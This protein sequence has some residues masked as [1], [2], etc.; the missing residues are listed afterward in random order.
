[1]DM[2]SVLDGSGSSRFKRRTLTDRIRH[3]TPS[4]FAASMG[5][6]AVSLIFHNF[7]YGSKTTLRYIATGFF[8]LDLCLFVSFNALSITRYVMYP[9]IWGLMIR[10]PVQSLFLACYPMA[11][12]TIIGESL[13]LYQDWNL[14]GVSFLY[15]IWGMCLLNV[16]L[17]M[18]STFGL[19]YYTITRH[20]QSLESMTAVWLLPVVQPV[21]GASTTA[22][23]AAVL[24]DVS[25]RHAL[26]T[27]CLAFGQLMIGLPLAFM[28]G[29]IYLLRLIVYGLPSSP[30]ITSM[31]LILGPLGQGGIAFIRISEVIADMSAAGLLPPPFFTDPYTASIVKFMGLTMA[32]FLWCFG[33]W[34]SFFAI[35]AII[36]VFSRNRVPF[37]V[38]FWGM[39]FPIGVYVL[40]TLQLAV[41]LDSKF[42]RV[43]G[44]ILGLAL[45][46]LWACIFVRTVF[47]AFEGS[48]FYAPCLDDMPLPANPAQTKDT[49]PEPAIE[50][51]GTSSAD[52]LPTV[53]IRNE[54]TVAQ[55]S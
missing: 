8:V 50:N 35:A 16:I 22:T 4:W 9:Q 46:L 21:V 6:G 14:G 42:F 33:L 31:F 43:T 2:D 30:F 32:L 40:L 26:L 36:E 18:T 47:L 24:L 12:A 54:E 15:F 1:M 11:F 23:M 48:M 3:F 20:K 10:H 39:T 45:I 55:P 19:L 41:T 28:I 25:P 29:T 5:T 37:G 44:T 13:N 34:W 7:P 52:R 51:P 27:L 17:T 53:S 38:P 49:E